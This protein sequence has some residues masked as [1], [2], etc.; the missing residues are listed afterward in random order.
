[1]KPEVSL[2]HIAEMLNTRAVRL[3]TL[4]AA[5]IEEFATLIESRLRMGGRIFFAGN[6]G[7]AA[8]AQHLAAEYVGIG[9]PALALTT[10][11][12]ILTALANDMGFEDVFAIQLWAHAPSS[13][14][15]V[16]IHSTSGRS[17]NLIQLAEEARI[18]NVPTIALLAG[19][20]GELGVVGVVDEVLIV[21]TDDV[22]I[23]QE[24]HMTVGHIVFHLV[25]DRITNG[26]PTRASARE[27]PPGA[28]PH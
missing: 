4:D 27:G 20:G 24:L 13:R 25:R 10:D 2:A 23:A 11:T 7:S 21:P 16:V 22:A 19:D 3:G 17:S 26:D 28:G 18:R 9:Y 15:V 14:D 5:R 6:G 1:M 8:D 12:S